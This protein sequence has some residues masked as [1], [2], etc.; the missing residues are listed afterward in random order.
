MNTR[1]CLVGISVAVWLLTGVRASAAQD[2]PVN[3]LDL[4]K[5]R[6]AALNIKGWKV[7]YSHRFDLSDL[8]EYRPSAPMRGTIRQWGS[9]YLADSP[10][11][12]WFE[13]T[14]GQHHPDV[15][16]EMYTD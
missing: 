5:A 9:N 3:S 10:L 1:A 13:Q 7:A 2:V 14:F 12:G 15:K 4:Q 8:P 6:A 11:Q 16:F